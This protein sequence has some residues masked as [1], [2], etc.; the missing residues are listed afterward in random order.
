MLLIDK[1][2]VDGRKADCH[3]HNERGKAHERSFTY[4]E[5]PVRF[6]P[7][8]PSRC[9]RDFWPLIASNIYVFVDSAE[10]HGHRFSI[11]KDIA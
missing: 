10:A 6:E 7:E 1:T 3:G 9:H 11:I 5:E 8:I 4:S 2:E